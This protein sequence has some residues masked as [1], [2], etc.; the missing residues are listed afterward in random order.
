MDALYRH[1]VEA[2]EHRVMTVGPHTGHTYQV[3]AYCK[4]ADTARVIVDAINA[5]TALLAE[6]ERGW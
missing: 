3:V 6:R 1:G 2:S 4:D 5:N